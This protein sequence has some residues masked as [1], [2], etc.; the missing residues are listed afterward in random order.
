[1]STRQQFSELDVPPGLDYDLDEI[2]EFAGATNYM[3]G[4]PLQ[5]SDASSID[6]LFGDV[7]P[8]S[9]HDVPERPPQVGSEAHGS[10]DDFDTGGAS[11]IGSA[12]YRTGRPQMQPGGRMQQEVAA[13]FENRDDM[14]KTDVL[15]NLESFIRLER[16]VQLARKKLDDMALEGREPQRFAP[17]MKFSFEEKDR[18]PQGKWPPYRMYYVG[19]GNGTGTIKTQEVGAD[20]AER[21]TPPGAT[22]PSGAPALRMEEPDLMPDVPAPAPPRT[23]AQAAQGLKP[24]DDAADFDP[25]M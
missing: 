10:M 1:M 6:D 18:G 3:D 17:I 2:S 15:V 23:A 16:A 12:S 25:L 8:M 9:V 5:E 20:I 13:G 22:P 24:I 11:P 4:V 21:N 7:T 19:I 14:T